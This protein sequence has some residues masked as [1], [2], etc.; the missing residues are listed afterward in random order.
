[1]A[2][3]VFLALYLRLGE[4]RGGPKRLRTRVFSMAHAL[5]LDSHR[6]RLLVPAEV[7][8]DPGEDRRVVA[9]PEDQVLGNG[10]TLLEDLPYDYREVLA[11][12]VL[13]DLSAED[14]AGI[15]GRSPGAVK[16][17]QRRALARLKDTIAEAEGRGSP[18]SR[19]ETAGADD[20]GRRRAGLS[21]FSSARMEA[22]GSTGSGP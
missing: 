18:M 8:Y 13:A 17:L 7:E 19:Q 14:T 21:S 5:A 3:E 20:G 2:Q 1:M 10:Q 22:G 6:R 16:Q 4:V 9:S 11:L 12:R 15:M